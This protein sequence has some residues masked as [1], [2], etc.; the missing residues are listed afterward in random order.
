[1]TAW[2]ATARG[3]QQHEDS[4][5][6]RAVTARGQQQHVPDLLVRAEADVHDVAV[7]ALEDGDGLPPLH[8]P[9]GAG[10]VPG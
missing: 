2:A 7:V 9:E 1:M 4:N 6:T 8:V 10:L 3:Q 5:S